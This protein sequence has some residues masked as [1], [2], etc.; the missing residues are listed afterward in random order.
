MGAVLS[1]FA[2]F[3]VSLLGD[4]VAYSARY[5]IARVIVS[6][7][8]ATITMTGITASINGLE[9]LIQSQINAAPIWVTSVLGL[10][11]FDYFVNIVFTA[12]L[13]KLFLKGLTAGG[14]ITRLVVKGSE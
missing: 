6:F 13:A 5:L 1:A 10:M 12:Y 14:S 3:L 2:T 7:G 4:V 9:S 11:G 8:L